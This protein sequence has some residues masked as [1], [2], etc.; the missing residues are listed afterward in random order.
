VEQNKEH[1]EWAAEFVGQ[2]YMSFPENE[3]CPYYYGQLLVKTGDLERARE[4]I[5]PIVRRKR[6]EFWAWDKLAATFGPDQ[7][8][9]RL[10]CLC[11]ALQCGVKNEGFLV[12]IH[13][14][15]AQIFAELER[16]PEAKYETE[17]AVQIREANDWKIPQPLRNMQS[18]SWYSDAAAATNNDDLYREYAPRAEEIIYEDLPSLPAVVVHQ[19]RS[20]QNRPGRTF[21]GYLHADEIKE[22]G[23]KTKLFACLAKAEQGRAMWVRIDSSGPKP[24]V[25]SVKERDAERWDIIA[26]QIGVVMHLNKEKGVTSVALDRN[27]FCLFHH[28]RF[29]EVQSI[30]PGTFVAVRALHDDRRD[31]LRALSFEIK[32]ETPPSSFCREFAGHLSVKDGHSFGFADQNVYIP[33]ELISGNGLTDGDLIKGIAV[34]QLNKRRNEYGWR[35]VA[36]AKDG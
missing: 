17:R 25:V 36:V 19:M 35:A 2:H 21:I 5:L 18:A 7:G 27:A 32:N 13:Q 23:I 26:T 33:G 11:K 16:F 22:V 29:P 20:A 4:L 9:I 3:W 34:M 14:K 12:K 15:L 8:E 1:I 31:M 10:A 6:G 28:D 24:V 30:H